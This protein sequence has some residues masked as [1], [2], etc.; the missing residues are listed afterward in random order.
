MVKITVEEGGQIVR[1]IEGD[2]FV[3]AIMSKVEKNL[4]KTDTLLVGS[5]SPANVAEAMGAMAGQVIKEMS[6]GNKLRIADLYARMDTRLIRI[7]AGRDNGVGVTMDKVADGTVHEGSIDDIA[8]DIGKEVAE[9]IK[10]VLTPGGG[11]A[12]GGVKEDKE[13]E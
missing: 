1:M 2:I 8:S 5:S 4:A 10:E 9:A 13:G 11:S 6:E 7:L 12:P 3:G